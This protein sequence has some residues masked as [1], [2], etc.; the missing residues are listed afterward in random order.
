MSGTRWVEELRAAVAIPGEDP[1]VAARRRAGAA[2]ATTPRV[3]LLES[4]DPRFDD[5]VNRRGPLYDSW[6]ETWNALA[7]TEKDALTHPAWLTAWLHATA[8]RDQAEGRDQRLALVR[9]EARVLTAV[10]FEVRPLAATV[11]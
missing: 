9:R 8:Q 10:P 7:D 6:L 11:N 4:D 2:A 3:D 5:L 1:A